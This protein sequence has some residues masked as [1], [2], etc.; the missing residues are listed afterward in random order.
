[1]S[2]DQ[3]DSILLSNT[4]VLLDN[5]VRGK[6]EPSADVKGINVTMRNFVI[7]PMTVHEWQ[8]DSKLSGVTLALGG[9][10]A[11]LHSLGQLQLAS[12]KL[13]CAIRGRP[14]QSLRH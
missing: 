2:L 3:I 8:A 1:M 14:C 11:R 10:T 7:S 9:W 5:V 4:E 6:L 13:E 12:G